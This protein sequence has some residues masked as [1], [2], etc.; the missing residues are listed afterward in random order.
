MLLTRAGHQ[1]GNSIS[2][3]RVVLFFFYSSFPSLHLFMVNSSMGKKNKVLY[4][5][6]RRSQIQ[7]LVLFFF[8]SPIRI[9]S[10]FNGMKL[11]LSVDY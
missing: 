4:F 3:L 8:S 11:I 10:P 5:R 2:F 7:V 1:I 6:G 9:F